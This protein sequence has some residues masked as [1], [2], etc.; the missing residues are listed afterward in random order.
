MLRGKE[1][2]EATILYNPRVRP[3]GQ[4][5][6]FPPALFPPPPTPTCLLPVMMPVVLRPQLL[7]LLLLPMVATATLLG[8]EAVG[9]R[10][11]LVRILPVS[12]PCLTLGLWHR[13]G[14]SQHGR[15]PCPF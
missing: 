3:R 7:L 1:A 10:R 9:D 4:K 12:M 6:H 11:S 5:L 13:G 15:R 14:M 8:E 2:F